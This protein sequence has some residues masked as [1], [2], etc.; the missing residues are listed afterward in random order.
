MSLEITLYTK[1]STKRNLVDELKALGYVRT[2]SIFDA[3]NTKDD[4]N[5]IWFTDKD[6]ESF[7]G[8]EADIRIAREE[9]KKKYDCSTWILHTR[10][11]S[12]GSYKDKEKQNQTIKHIRKLSGGT[13][14]NDWYGTN[15]YIKLADY[16]MLTA[17]ERGLLLLKENI[18]NKISTL[19]VTLKGYPDSIIKADINTI[20]D[21]SFQDFLRSSE[22]SLTL[23][24]AMF[25][26]LVSM[27]EFMFK[28]SFL[29]M[30]KYSKEAQ[31]VIDE[32]NIKVHLKDVIQV[33]EGKLTIEDII[34]DS[35]TF[36]NLGQVNRAFN[37]YLNIDIARIL[38]RKK[39]VDNKFIRIYQK[40]E[41]IINI[42]HSIVHHFGFYDELDKKKFLE[43][44]NIVEATLYEFTNYLHNNTESKNAKNKA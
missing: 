38:S 34:A 1:N 29:I 19:K 12:S 26:F 10:T 20:Q 22:P 32:E 23:Y 42:R 2:K 44:L 6:Y 3:L 41:D 13:F 30:I 28:E 37:K 40:I 21:K 11:L 4:L 15:K 8:V 36:Q 33:S 27:I 35:F 43:Y 31:S 25:P 18:T 16:P 24:N 17:P 5:Y 9:E 39:K 7:T 14:Y